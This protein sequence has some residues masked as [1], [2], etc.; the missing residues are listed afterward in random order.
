MALMGCTAFLLLAGAASVRLEGFVGAASGATT[1]AGS[2]LP[3]ITPQT[4]GKPMRAAWEKLDYGLFKV[5]FDESRNVSWKPGP[6]PTGKQEEVTLLTFPGRARTARQGSLW[7]VDCDS[8]VPNNNP[9]QLV[10]D[11]WSTGFDGEK[12]Y[13][14]QVDQMNGLVML[15]EIHYAAE[16]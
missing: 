9:P 5:E 12:H 14:W 13:D 11:R 6:N 1:R 2:R 7:R 16:Q 4:L 8:M 15:G 3:D 10:P